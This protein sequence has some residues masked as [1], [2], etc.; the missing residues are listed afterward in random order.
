MLLVSSSCFFVIEIMG[1]TFTAIHSGILC[2]PILGYS[3]T[4]HYQHMLC[5]VEHLY[6]TSP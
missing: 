3:F 1:E 5:S 2:G 4:Q 6:R